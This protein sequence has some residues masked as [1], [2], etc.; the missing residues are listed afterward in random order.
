MYNAQIVY[1]FWKTGD[2]VAQ[3]VNLGHQ[4]IGAPLIDLTQL[5][6]GICFA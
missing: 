4:V 5:T 1:V 2:N 3:Y 6:P